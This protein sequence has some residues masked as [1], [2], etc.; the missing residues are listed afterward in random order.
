[1][2]RNP[3]FVALF[4]FVLVFIGGAAIAGIGSTP[5][6]VEAPDASA[7]FDASGDVATE[8]TTTKPPADDISDKQVEEKER[9]S[10]KDT[11]PPRFS[12][13]SPENGSQVDTHIIEVSGAVEEGAVVFLGDRLADQHGNRW[14]MEVEL[15]EGRNS[16]TFKARDEA[17][18]LSR[19]TLFVYFAEPDTTPPRFAITSPK[20]GSRTT[21]EVITVRGEVEMGSKVF[22]GD[23]PARVDGE[24]WKINVALRLGKNEL[25]FTAVDEAGNRTTE[26]LHITRVEKDDEHEGPR[27][28]ITS[29]ANGTETDDKV[30]LVKGGVTPGSKVYFGDQQAR[31][32]G[33]DWQIEVKLRPGKNELWFK[34]I[35]ESGLKTK[36]SVTVWYVGADVEYEFWAAQKYGSCGEETPYDVF[37]GKAK[38]G[39]VIEVGSPYGSGRV[40]VGKEGHWEL[41]VFFEGSPTGE[42][43]KVTVYASTGETKHF[44][45]VNTGAGG[46]H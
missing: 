44:T 26:T 45:F 11:T 24:L 30:I 4:A 39:S 32:E 22:Y 2:K 27:F 46:D 36:A 41:K 29:P 15:K 10:D 6:V 34:A 3:I 17:G 21:Y 37:Y 35:D 23:D 13:L 43:F 9:P 7:S 28:T 40:E 20:D 25:Q 31:V 8:T 14:A 12:I 16:L 33:D 18:N 19:R 38:P 5:Q 1:M 42:P